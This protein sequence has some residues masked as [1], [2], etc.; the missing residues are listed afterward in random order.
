LS[1]LGAPSG[2]TR[3]GRGFSFVEVLLAVLI[4]GLL[5]TSLYGLLY[6]TIQVKEIVQGE[7]D[8]EKAGSMAFDLLRRDV[9][10][11]CAI[12]EGR[13]FFK[14]ERGGSR[15]GGRGAD[16]VDFVASTRNRFPDES[17]Q[18]ARGDDAERY[19]EMNCDLCEI[20]YR[21]EE[22]GDDTVLV[23]REDFYVDGDLE[24]GG[25]SMI[26]CRGVEKFEMTFLEGD[27]DETGESEA[28]EWD[29]E[30]EEA[31]PFAVKVRLVLDRS[32]HEMEQREKVFE[33]VIPVH[34]GKP[35]AA[36]GEED[37]GRQK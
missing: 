13:Y 15:G 5:M 1:T 29:A 34:A 17:A 23:R 25:V 22:V 10:S 3:S 35:P 30:K 16:K 12:D 2:T 19:E 21:L 14:A 24:A 31:L 28:D 6:S 37:E 20:G 32:R 27:E 9:E 4:T 7:L 18:K 8:D 26:V 36:E 33:A 11:A